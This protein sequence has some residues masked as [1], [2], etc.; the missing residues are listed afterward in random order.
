[1]PAW[2]QAAAL[3][4]PLQVDAGGDSGQDV[5]QEALSA[6]GEAIREVSRE[7]RLDA[8]EVELPD[9]PHRLRTACRVPDRFSALQAPDT[10]AIERRRG[11]S[12]RPP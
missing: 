1:M 9:T 11:C 4:R 3:V 10:L 7:M 2:G 5:R 6:F 12:F 8:G